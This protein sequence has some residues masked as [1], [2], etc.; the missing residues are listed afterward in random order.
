MTALIEYQRL[1]AP[2]LWRETPQDQRREVIVSFGDATLVIADARSE[3]PLAH[4]SLPALIRLNPGKSPAVYVP[5]PEPGEDLEIDD[6][7]MIAAIEK[8]HAAIAA[9]RPHPGRL[10]HV[11]AGGVLLAA[12][13]LGVF[14]LPGALTRHAAAVAPFSARVE[15]GRA[16]L[17]EL[18][19]L[20]GTPCAAPDTARP[21]R[22]LAERLLGPGGRIVVV[23]AALGDAR[24]LPGRL[25]VLGRPL[26]EGQDSPEVAAGH[27]IA[28]ALSAEIEDPLH[29]LLAWA[30]IGTSLKLLTSGALPVSA[31]AGYGAHL[32]D[33]PPAAPA[34][35]LLLEAFAEAGVPSTPYAFSRDPSGESVLGLI[36]GDPLRGRPM[37]EPLMPDG[38]WVLLQ[39]I[40]AD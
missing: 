4:W 11:L 3:R 20:T 33:A 39:G 10:R 31:L 5:G 18:S 25:V 28:A 38:D 23:P 14:W 22:A 1:E 29:A 19:T 15:I 37:P 21:L 36:E 9:R 24:M 35:D 30:G 12:L 13:G 17:T 6:D 27:I 8:V 16:A 26:V 34:D 40:C 7:T 2:G 32:L